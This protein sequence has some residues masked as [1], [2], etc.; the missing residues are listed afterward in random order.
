MK[1]KP[2]YAIV[3]IRH[4]IQTLRQC[5]K[6][7]PALRHII[8]VQ[9]ILYKR[10]RRL[11]EGCEGKCETSTELKRVYGQEARKIDVGN[12]DGAVG[13]NERVVVLFIGR[14]RR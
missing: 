3:P 9:K 10:R 7:A 8:D 1:S 14:Q 2:R 13:W 4:Q 6:P 5:R 12:D 11:A